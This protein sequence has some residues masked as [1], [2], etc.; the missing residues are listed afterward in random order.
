M[1][2]IHYHKIYLEINF[3]KYV[4]TKKQIADRNS[5]GFRYVRTEDSML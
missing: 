3:T 5:R 1:Y 2:I 4:K